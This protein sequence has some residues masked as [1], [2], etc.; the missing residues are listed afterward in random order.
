[1]STYACVI[2]A[3]IWSGEW[4]TRLESN[5]R[6][7]APEANALSPE[8]RAPERSVYC[9][10]AHHPTGGS[11]AERAVEEHVDAADAA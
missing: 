2:I 5:Q 8:L 1:M 9:D 11:G 10:A 6:P 3:K 4:C 7:F